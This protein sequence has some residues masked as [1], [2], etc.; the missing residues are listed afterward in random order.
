MTNSFKSQLSALG[1]LRLGLI[2]LAVVNMLIPPIDSLL[3]RL[4]A[5]DLSD[6][7]WHIF[8]AL[9]APVM[10]PILLV[11]LFC[12]Y[13]MSRI[14]AADAEGEIRDHFIAVSRIELMV[15]VIMTLFWL[16]F[17]ISIFN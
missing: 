6:S 3:I 14:Q 15:M 12:D 10:A 5:S 11:I 1:T 9:V 7:L 4:T 17:F 16:P 8:P 13:L 2:I